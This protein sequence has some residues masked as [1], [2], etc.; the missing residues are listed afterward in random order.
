MKKVIF[1]GEV[2]PGVG[3]ATALDALARRFPRGSRETLEAGLFTGGD[4][5]IKRTADDAEARRYARAFREAGLLVEI[6]DESAADDE[7]DAPT[8]PA[9]DADSKVEASAADPAGER[10]ARRRPWRVALA[11]GLALLVAGA[12]AAWYTQPVWRAGT[13]TAAQARYADALADGG[14]VGLA[15]VDIRRTAALEARMLG[16]YDD[17]AL[18]GTDGLVA[19]LEAAGLAPREAIDDILYALT[20]DPGTGA[21]QHALV[22]LGRFDPEAV[23]AWIG[24]RYS[25]ERFDSETA[26][27][28]F[29]TG[30]GGDCAPGETLAA[31]LAA[32]RIVVGPPDRVATIEER[33]DAGAAASVDLADWHALSRRQVLTAG[34]FAPEHAGAAAEGLAA[35]LLASAGQQARA[36]SALYAGATPSLL[37]PGVVFSLRADSDDDA[38]LGRVADGAREVL[39]DLRTDTDAWPELV[40]IY[41]RIDIE[42][43]GDSLTGTLQLDTDFADEIGL[44]AQAAIARLF[45]FGPSAAGASEQAER[46]VDDPPRY[47]GTAGD[48]PAPFDH[49]GNTAGFA[50]QGGPF[51]AGVRSAGPGSG[52]G[53][54]IALNVEARE[55]TTLERGSQLLRVRIDDVVDA[56]GRSLL[57]QTECEA[58]AGD[59][60]HTFDQHTQGMVE[61]EAEFEHYSGLLATPGITLAADATPADV[62]AIRG[63]I[64]Y[65]VPTAVASGRV[66]V[67]LAGAVADEAGVRLRFTGGGPGRIAYIASGEIER[68]LAVRALNEAGRVLARGSHAAGDLLLASGRRASAQYH[69]KVAAAEYFIAESFDTRRHEFEIEG[70]L[71]LMAVENPGPPTPLPAAASPDSFLAALERDPPT[72]DVASRTLEQHTSAGPLLVGV[73][74]LRS[75]PAFGLSVWLR[76]Y[77]PNALPL[78]HR[79]NAALVRI[80]GISGGGGDAVDPGISQP[81]VLEPASAYWMNGEYRVDPDR[82]WLRGG[83]NVLA[84]DYTGD[85]PVA[86]SGEVV[87]R[88][89]HAITEHAMPATPGARYATE[90][91]SADVVRW[92]RGNLGPTIEIAV[93]GDTER[94]VAVTAHDVDGRRVDQGIDMTPGEDGLDLALRV[95]SAPTELRLRLAESMTTRAQPFRIDIDDPGQAQ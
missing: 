37:P 11:A 86:L 89:V 63:T 75:N 24:A 40:P 51:G 82:P 44:L 90:R 26:T 94:L 18:P 20:V 38:F 95:G 47:A 62:A 53:A 14:L 30:A 68:L 80:D 69:G 87:M 17:N 61:R 85:S 29:S 49:W 12:A 70:G 57:R 79:L 65:R 60:W 45:D 88:G 76:V 67:P 7:S 84:P 22:L 35:S 31:R 9:A 92:V 50:W 39:E 16:G 58:R 33:A 71:P 91:L 1:R 74:H 72:V 66:D 73:A 93:A 54:A 46:I 59:E 27:V 25:V 55:L 41:E 4:V 3:R 8:P 36:V 23:R 42:R 19:S 56:R 34:F 48:E 52:G 2:A 77:A 64:E 10:A 78:A 43:A 13:T 81:F 32:D 21:A 6:R 5:V 28:R 83:A 15:H